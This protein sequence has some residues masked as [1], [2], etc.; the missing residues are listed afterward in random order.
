MCGILG[1][2]HI[3]RT[4]SPG[5]LEAG[6]AALVHRGPDQQGSYTSPYISLGA[7]RLRIIDIEGGD[8]PIRSADGNAVI[9]FNG[10]I[11]NHRELRAELEALGAKFRTHSDTEVA[12]NAFLAWGPASFARLRGMFGVAIWFEAERRLV[13]ARDRMGIKPLYYS[14]QN[15]ELSFGSEL[16]CIFANPDVPRRIDLAGLNCYLSLNYVPGPYTLV[17]GISKLMPGCMLNWQDGRLAIASYAPR[18]QSGPVP[19]SLEEACEEL[20]NLLTQSVSEQ[21]VSEAP[22]GMWLS[23]GLDSSTVLHYAAKLSPKRLKT[24]SVTFRGKSFDESRYIEQ[25]AQ[26]YGSDH[27]EFDLNEEADLADVIGELAYYSDEPSADAGAVPVWYLAKM[28]RKDVTVVLSGEGADELFGGY[29]TYKADR[30]S[31]YFSLLPRAF[32]AAALNL[33]RRMPAS[34]EK[35]GFDYKLKRFLEGSLLSPEAAHV[36]WNGTFTEGEKKKLFRF[37]HPGPLNGILAEMRPRHLRDSALERFLDFDQRYSLP[38]GILYKVDRMS[39][40]HS[41]EVRPPFLD[42]RIVRLAS[43]LPDS[44]KINGF[45]TKFIL[46][47]LMRDALP[48]DVLKRPKVGF[49]IPIHQWFRGVLRGLL[50]ETL[51][52]ASVTQNGLFNW[53]AVRRLIDEHLNRKANWGY[54]LWGLVTLLLWMKRWKIEAPEVQ[55]F[56]YAA[57]EEASADVQALAWQPASYSPQTSEL[58]LQ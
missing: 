14:V 21:L 6:I 33:A 34:D 54:H 30:Y 48:P 29:L 40:A 37:A 23:G 4:L 17:D 50:T 46:R 18:V 57:E 28:T 3:G 15:G 20:D 22:L 11:Y 26:C 13:L 7:T 58:P 9:A 5:V 41:V 27:T 2:T 35:I 24:F 32:R 47:H 43:R 12:L 52:E 49:D 53:V 51:N 56:V 31:R 42:P 19:G 16:K 25:V 44:Y 8:Q 39:M 10:E 55:R 36:F 38:D 45:Q 1:Y